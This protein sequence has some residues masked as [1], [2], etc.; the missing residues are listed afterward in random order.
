MGG[1][2]SK[3]G[4]SQRSLLQEISIRGLGV[5]DNATVEFKS[6]LNVITGETGA[7]KT[8]L[9]TA[10][11]LILGGKADSQL[12]RVGCER[13]STSGRF[14]L[15]SK[16]S[17]ELTNILDEHDILIEEG[18]VLLNRNVSRD[19]KSRAL[20]GGTNTTAAVL[21]ELSGEL[22]EIH[23]QHSNL[24]LSKPNKQREILDGFCG[25]ELSDTL[26]VYQAHLEKF[27][28]LKSKI[29]EVTKALGDKERLISQ[30]REVE[31]DYKKIKPREEELSE[32][33]NT[34]SKLESVEDIRFAVSG[35][36]AALQDEEIGALN[37]LQQGKRHLQGIRGKDTD[38][39][40]LQERISDSLFNLV[41]AAADLER[42]LQGL[43]ADPN[44]LESSLQ[45][46]SL[47]LNYLKKHG[48]ST[49]RS[50]AFLEAIQAGISASERI[51][52]LSGGDETI[53]RLQIELKE[54]RKALLVSAQKVSK[55][56]NE[57]AIVFGKLVE[58]ELHS[59]SMPKAKLNVRIVSKSGEID[60]DFQ[61]HGLDEIS[62]DFSAHGGTEL[63]PI[64]KA[65]SGG[66][67][68]RLMLGI[69]V[70]I[71]N[72]YPVGTYIFDEVDAGVGGK[73]ALDVGRRLKKLAEQAQVIVVTHLPQVAIW[74]DH[75]ILVEKNSDGA[76]TESSIR[77][78]NDAE[79]EVEIARMLSGLE[80]SEH[81]QEHARELLNL[82][83]AEKA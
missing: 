35:A 42:Y 52:E 70:V 10:L 29:S 32:L 72:S 82:R 49:D 6:G 50:T 7:G 61:T 65:A 67:L 60:S 45:R 14:A 79:R 28:S 24:V 41:D 19:G 17:K 18:S 69:E 11:S 15:P 27:T 3:K 46:R 43:S 5:I 33:D 74:A 20:A 16:P 56:R 71:A 23:G 77:T 34:I 81:A 9:L 62:I 37:G 38:L 22:I 26:V 44:A 83:L 2:V 80:S 59:L 68:S 54:T 58:S 40:V 66:E 31:A 63:L 4:L 21:N 39:D 8:M 12:V 75:Q 36:V 55:I 53:E 48:K 73:A 57:K 51:A 30:L 25:P 13:A 1:A 78:L 76:V 64:I 47:L